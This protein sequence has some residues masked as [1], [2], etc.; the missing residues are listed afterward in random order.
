[1][2][3]VADSTTSNLLRHMEDEE[4]DIE[5]PYC[6]CGNEPI[7]QEQATNQCMGCGKPIA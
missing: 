1:M 7:E 2:R 6:N 3:N 4:D 5:E